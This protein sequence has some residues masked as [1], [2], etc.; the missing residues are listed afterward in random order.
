MDHYYHYQY[1]ARKLLHV[2]ENLDARRA[3]WARIYRQGG[4]V[5]GELR[6]S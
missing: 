3:L 1:R 5:T 4:F 6:L 2:E